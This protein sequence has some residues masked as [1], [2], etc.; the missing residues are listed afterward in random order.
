MFYGNET[1]AFWLAPRRLAP[2]RVGGEGGGEVGR[3]KCTYHADSWMQMQAHSHITHTIKPPM[4]P[5]F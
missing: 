3:E 1:F 2:L 5:S 4:T